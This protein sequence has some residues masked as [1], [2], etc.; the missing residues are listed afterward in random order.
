MMAIKMEQGFSRLKAAAFAWESTAFPM[1]TGTLITAAGFLPIATARSS[2]GEYTRSLFEVVTIA[3][4][5]VVD[6]RRRLHSLSSATSCCPITGTPRSRPGPG[7]LPARWHGLRERLADRFPACHDFLAPKPPIDGTSTTV[8]QQVLHTIPRLGDVLRAPRWLVIGVTAAAFVAS[9]FLFRFVPQ[10]FFPDSTR[11]EADGRHRTGR[12][13]FAARHD[14][15]G[16]T[17]GEDPGAAQGAWKA[18][19][20][21]SA[22]AHRVTTCRSTSSCLRPTSRSSC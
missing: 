21:T 6:C 2:T 17:T 16:A 22:P 14:H 12:R 3:L 11:P 18:T 13:Q 8:R 9:V 19:S 15:A 10:Q 5:G 1:L 4:V 20:L 7:S